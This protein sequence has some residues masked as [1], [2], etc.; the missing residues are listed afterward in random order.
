M[1]KVFLS[2]II[3]LFSITAVGVLPV[4]HSIAYAQKKG[5]DRPKKEPP[6]PPVVK[7]KEPKGDDRPKERPPK[8]KKP[9]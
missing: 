2:I 5:E 3:A 7:D 4:E 6:G 9:D 8:N 1:K